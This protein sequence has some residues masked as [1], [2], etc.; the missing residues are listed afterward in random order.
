[1]LGFVRLALVAAWIGA[2]VSQPVAGA[3]STGPTK[4]LE[5]RTVTSLLP[6]FNTA[7]PA[8]TPAFIHPPIPPLLPVEQVATLLT[9]TTATTFSVLG[10]AALQLVN[11]ATTLNID[12]VL[13]TVPS[14]LNGV[15]CGLFGCGG[16]PKYS[17]PRP[18]L[19]QMGSSTCLDSK[20][21]A[22]V[23]NSL[24]YCACDA[25]FVT[26]RRL[27]LSLPADGGAGTTVNLC[28]NAHI[29]LETSIYFYAANQ[30]LQT[31]GLPFDSTRAVL[32]VNDSS[33]TC[34]IY[35]ADDGNNGVTLKNVIINGNRDGLGWAP[36]GLA[37]IEMGGNNRGQVIQNVKSYDPRG[38]S[39]L[40][41]IEGYQ[42]SCSGSKVLNNELGP[43]GHAPSGAQ[44]FRMVKMKRD[45]GTYPPGQWADG[46]SLACKNSIATGNTC[47]NDPVFFCLTCC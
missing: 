26:S 1:M 10:Q 13:K 40:H 8:P 32:T 35:G 17:D 38:W 44:Q 9:V 47:V 46:L 16:R 11:S 23:I 14:L 20:Y 12:G 39:A 33:T 4:T 43:S 28:P 5:R 19:Q 34:A 27:T 29:D 25:S 21:N 3:G 6:P 36:N 22:S 42:N 15:L 45:T 41:L 24:F 30:T 2:V 31:G 7:S 37:L 18:P